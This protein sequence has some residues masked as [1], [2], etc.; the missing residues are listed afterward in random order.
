MILAWTLG[1]GYSGN[2]QKQRDTSKGNSKK[3][4]L[5]G[6]VK[7]WLIRTDTNYKPPTLAGLPVCTRQIPTQNTKYMMKN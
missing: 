4:S 3:C 2:G 5:A 6:I 1:G 7:A